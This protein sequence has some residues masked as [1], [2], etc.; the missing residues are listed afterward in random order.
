MKNAPLLFKEKLNAGGMIILFAWIS[1]FAAIAS[2]AASGLFFV[3]VTLAIITH[4]IVSGKKYVALVCGK[5]EAPF[6]LC[7][8]ALMGGLVTV[9]QP[10][11][12]KQYFFQF[13]LPIPAIYFF[14]RLTF[15][16][17]FGKRI[18]FALCGMAVLATLLG[19]AEFVTKRS[20]IYEHII[21]NMYYVPF[22]GK[23]MIS[24]HLHPTPLGTYLVAV[25]PLLLVLA[26]RAKSSLLR[27]AY[28]LG[29][30]L[31]M[32][33]VILTFSRGAFLGALA[34]I[35]TVSLFFGK[36]KRKLIPFVLAGFGFCVIAFSS[37]F[38]LRGSPGF[39]RFSTKAL[40]SG[41]LYT[42]KIDRVHS[43]GRIMR[44][45]PFIGLG[46][47]HFRVWFD[48]YLPQLAK[49]VGYDGKVPDCMYLALLVETGLIGFSGFT[50]FIFF[51][52]K[53]TRRLLRFAQTQGSDEKKFFI[54]CFLPGLL[55]IMVTF[56]TY[57]TLYWPAP[58]LLFW[59]YCGILSSLS[60]SSNAAP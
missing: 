28:S 37:W 41:Y 4:L 56:L 2:P 25:M 3:A 23:R 24:T 36:H 35:G 55:G 11:V 49:K 34:G 21:K 44:D 9:A 30:C 7:F 12:A 47:G 22:R 40:S 39:Y 60:T 57:D 45:H 38:F 14:S 46:F 43:I 20:F 50:V 8:L 26:L 13:V 52:L 5:E 53:R 1:F 54:V 27:L 6:W 18:V 42:A 29:W 15:H 58:S 19:I 17:R 51:L 59:S 48:Y 16:P 10:A 33:G 31:L 32:A